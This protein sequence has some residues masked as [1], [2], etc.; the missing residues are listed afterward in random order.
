LAAGS[1][2]PDDPATFERYFTSL[3]QIAEME[4]GKEIQK[5]REGLRYERVANEF[6][7]IDDDAISV[8]VPYAGLDAA[9]HAWE[10]AAEAAALRNEFERAARSPRPTAGRDL[11]RRSQPYLVSVRRRPLEQAAAKGWATPL[12]GD[13]WAW[14]G[15]YDR[16]RGLLP[17]GRE[18]D[19]LVV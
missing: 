14:D 3:F 4:K 5:L 6:Q 11:L 15:R 16:I 17:E 13:I 9:R 1:I 19:A 8:L 2:Y 18:L 7:M 10:T 12:I